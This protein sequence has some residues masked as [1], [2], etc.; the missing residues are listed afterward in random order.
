MCS[1]Q[2]RVSLDRVRDYGAH[3]QTVKGMW[4]PK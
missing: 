2:I 1:C 4:L 3:A